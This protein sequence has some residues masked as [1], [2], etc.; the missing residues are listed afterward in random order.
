MVA[1]KKKKVKYQ[2]Q[3]SDQCR[4]S[5]TD[6][7]RFLKWLKSKPR[8]RTKKPTVDE[9]VHEFTKGS[10]KGL[11]EQDCKEAAKKYW[12]TEAQYWLRHVEIIKVDIITNDISK[13]VNAYVP[14][15]RG[16]FGR[17]KENDY[18]SMQRVDNS[19]KM[20]KDII[21]M[22]KADLEDYLN[23]YERYAEFL[24]VFDSIIKPIRT[25]LERLKD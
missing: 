2:Y 1:T 4:R 7:E 24:E 22:A 15:K 10:L 14:I 3:M 8:Y 11:V 18:K 23:R 12:R 6:T 16:Q 5:A 13:P 25:L 20:S 17:I 9:L 21:E 19:K